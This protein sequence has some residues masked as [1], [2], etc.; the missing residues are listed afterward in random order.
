[1]LLIGTVSGFSGN[2]CS[3][4]FLAFLEFEEGLFPPLPPLRLGRLRFPFPRAWSEAE[5]VDVSV[6]C[7]VMPSDALRDDE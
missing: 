2:S 6:A 1:M 7:S 4:A 3:V 5:G